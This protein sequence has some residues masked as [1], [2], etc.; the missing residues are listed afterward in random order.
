MVWMGTAIQ[1]RRQSLMW[2]IAVADVNGKKGKGSD[3]EALMSVVC[4]IW[5]PDLR[6]GDRVYHVTRPDAFPPRHRPRAQ[7]ARSAFEWRLLERHAI[8]LCCETRNTMRMPQPRATG[9]IYRHGQSSNNPTGGLEQERIDAS[10]DTMQPQSI[11]I[12]H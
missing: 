3:D 10:V 11:F 7:G 5:S 8:D 6:P 4:C 9:G 2:K 1:V 12:A